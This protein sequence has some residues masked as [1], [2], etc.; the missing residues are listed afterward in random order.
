MKKSV[1][2]ILAALVLVSTEAMAQLPQPEIGLRVGGNLAQLRGNSSFGDEATGRKLGFTV[3]AFAEMPLGGGVSVQPELLYTQKGGTEEGVD[4]NL[5]YL[6]LPVLVKYAAPTGSR[7]VPSLYAGPF[8]GYSVGR[9]FE[10]EG[11]SIDADEVFKRANYGVAF[12]AD[13]GYRF[14][15]RTATVGLRYDLGLANV[16]DDSS[17][18][19][20]F[21]GVEARTHEVSAGFLRRCGG[22]A[23]GLQ[24]HHEKV[25]L[26]L[27]LAADMQERSRAA[28]DEY[29]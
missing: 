22:F 3:G 10:A 2:V 28:V 11:V 6:E 25:E 8:V 1:V 20:E 29:V 5:D 19:G 15:R 17:I 18:G 23:P 21:D 14:D 16:F 4:F 26:P 24:T 27:Q 9:A 12:G 7:V 13:F